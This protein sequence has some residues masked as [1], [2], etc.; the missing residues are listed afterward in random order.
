MGSCLSISV[1]AALYY[2]ERT[3]SSCRRV[4]NRN[5]DKYI[6][7]QNQKVCNKCIDSRKVEKT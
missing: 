4:L 3:C 1:A 5:R 2:N 7:L 6:C